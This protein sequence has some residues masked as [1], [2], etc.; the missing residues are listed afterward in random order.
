MVCGML[1]VTVYADETPDEE[2]PEIVEQDNETL[3][4]QYTKHDEVPA[5]YTADG[6]REYYTDDEGNKYIKDETTYT[7]VSDEDLVIPRLVIFMRADAVSQSSGVDLNMYFPLPDGA[8]TS[9]YTL[10]F[11]NASRVATEC[12]TRDHDA[13]NG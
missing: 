5:S 9:E 11:G 4:E 3:E 12:E 13:G 6:T 8:D 1:P 10:T 2:I 7:P